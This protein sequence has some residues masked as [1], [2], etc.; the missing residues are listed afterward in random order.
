[1]TNLPRFQQL[2]AELL[3]N[4]GFELDTPPAEQD[5]FSLAVDDAYT[6]HLGMMNADTWF[7]LAEL[8]NPLAPHA[9]LSDWLRANALNDQPL[10][11]VIALDEMDRPCCYLRLPLDGYGLPD[12]MA[13]FNATLA[14]ADML[15]GQGA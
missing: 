7:I 2:V 12:L 14:Q 4:I 5:L 11:P 15:C 1:M 9:P 8:P 3:N 6:L 13:A 10:Q